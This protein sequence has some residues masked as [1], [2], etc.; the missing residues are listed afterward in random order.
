[1]PDDWYEQE[2]IREKILVFGRAIQGVKPF[3]VILE[4]DQA[5]CHGAY[6]SFA[7]EMIIVNPTLFNVFPEEQYL[8]TKALLVHEAGHKRHT[9]PAIAPESIRE[10]S[11]ILEDERVERL[12]CHEFVGIRWL[13]D[14][15]AGRFYE[16]SAPI[17][18]STD[19]SE[20]VISYFLQLRWAKRISQPVKGSLSKKNQVLWKKVE[21]LVYESWKADNSIDVRR[22]ATK[23][24]EILDIKHIK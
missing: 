19:K 18:S 8:L 20:Q 24:A 3:E 17:D 2:D 10:I 12:M 15:L 9:I 22:N 14:K 5:K 4:P 6:C 13:I 1:M 7:T 23:I 16:D 11:N 21:P